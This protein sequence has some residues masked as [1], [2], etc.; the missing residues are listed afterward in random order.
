M[1]SENRLRGD[2]RRHLTQHAASKSMPE[3]REAPSLH[4]IQP[5]P[6][7]SQLRFQCAILLAEER[8]D[9]MLLAHEPSKQRGK[10]HL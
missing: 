2:E 5:Q 7:S 10:E 9:I 8:D 3:H 4:I 6:A 1:P